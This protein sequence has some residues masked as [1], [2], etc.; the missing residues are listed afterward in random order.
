LNANGE[1]LLFEANAAMN[2]I[3]PDSDKRWS[4]RAP[5]IQRI[6]SAVKEMLLKKADHKL[7]A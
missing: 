4:Y 2:V 7:S 6:F 3:P 5:P 1:I